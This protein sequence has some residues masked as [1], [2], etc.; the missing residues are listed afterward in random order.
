M[1]DSEAKRLQEA[2]SFHLGDLINRVAPG[3]LANTRRVTASASEARAENVVEHKT[4]LAVG[5][6]GAIHFIALITKEDYTLLHELEAELESRVKS[7]GGIKH[8]E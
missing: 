8:R 5:I 2:A 6:S 1:E 3:T 7:V 4:F